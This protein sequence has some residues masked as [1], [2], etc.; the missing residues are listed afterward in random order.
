MYLG[1]IVRIVLV[2]FKK[3]GYILSDTSIKSTPLTQ[4]YKFETAYMSRIERDHS[5]NLSD[6]DSIARMLAYISQACCVKS[7]ALAIPA[8]RI[9]S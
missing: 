8:S 3:T 1:E 7:C 2:D 5:H 9:E 6:V 4:P